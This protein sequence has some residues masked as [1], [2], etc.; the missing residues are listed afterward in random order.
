[1]QKPPPRRR[2]VVSASLRRA[3]RRAAEAARLQRPARPGGRRPEYRPRA[4]GISNTVHPG[5]LSSRRME[6]VRARSSAGGGP[7]PQALVERGSRA[8]RARQPEETAASGGAPQL[9]RPRSAGAPESHRVE[10]MQ[11]AAA[12][13]PQGH[14]CP[15][16]AARVVWPRP[17][18]PRTRGVGAPAAVRAARAVGAE[19]TP[20]ASVAWVLL[21]RAALR[22][23][24]H[25]AQQEG[26]APATDR[27]WMAGDLTC[28]G[29]RGA[30]RCTRAAANEREGEASA[31]RWRRGAPASNGKPAERPA[32]NDGGWTRCLKR[33][34]GGRYFKYR[35]PLGQ[36][37]P[38]DGRC[39]GEDRLGIAAISKGA[40]PV[41]VPRQGRRGGCAV[42]HGGGTWPRSAGKFGAAASPS[43]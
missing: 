3:T 43:H 22:R 42:R 38:S 21:P 25:G 13:S 15:A 28:R 18:L 31:T 24:T 34:P 32:C 20:M 41:V 23:A 30:S 39:A 19:A 17:P 35:P 33:R 11:V 36:F 6:D 10:C 5:P 9:C 26:S 7:E 2:D 16:S 4:D 8:R 14:D 12:T 29:W 40:E 37:Q 1:M 27:R